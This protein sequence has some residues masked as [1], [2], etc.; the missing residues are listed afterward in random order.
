MAAFCTQCGAAIPPSAQVRPRG[1]DRQELDA[2]I[3]QRRPGDTRF[4]RG[5]GFEGGTAGQA[6]Y[7][8]FEP[9]PEDARALREATEPL[10]NVDHTSA[11]FDQSPAPAPEPEVEPRYE[12]PEQPG[13]AYPEAEPY[14]PPASAYPDAWQAEEEEEP[15]RG[16]GMLPVIGF[17]ALAILALGVGAALA[18]MFGGGV[19]RSSATPTPSLAASA[20]TDASLEATPSEG[21]ATAS[22]EPTDGPVVFPDGAEIT[23]QSCATQQM[24][25]DGCAVDGST[26]TERTM[27]VWIGFKHAAGNDTFTLEL[28]SGDQ[29]LDQQDKELGSILD[30][31]GTCSGYLIGAVYRDLDPGDYQLIVRRND[32]FADSASFTVQ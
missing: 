17:V 15:R 24:S 11:G 9:D 19:A 1:M 10:G 21:E 29:T 4:R 20:S 22:P 27:W 30:C 13:D 18:G 32:D 6:G 31:P 23:V 12:A 14:V 26:I 25:F 16:M 8:P 7:V 3:R 2:R 28:R 5:G